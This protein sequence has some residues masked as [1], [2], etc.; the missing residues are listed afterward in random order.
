MKKNNRLEYLTELKEKFEKS[1]DYTTRLG[2]LTHLGNFA[3]NPGNY[4]HFKKLNLVEFFL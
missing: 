4:E 3:Y 2:C 1:K